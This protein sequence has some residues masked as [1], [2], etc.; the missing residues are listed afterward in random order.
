MSKIIDFEKFG[1]IVKFYLGDVDCEDYWGDDWD[2][3]PYEHNAGPV[4]NEYVIGTR[5]I[6]FDYDDFVLEPCESNYN[7]WSKED[8]KKGIIPCIVVVPNHL[9]NEYEEPIFDRFASSNNPEIKKFYFNDFL[10]PGV[11]Y[12]TK[13]L[14]EY[15]EPVKTYSK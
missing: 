13:E 10:I 14:N 11:S 7:Q 6:Y 8:M 5:T 15:F 3:I 12:D 1:T 4:Y 9:F 2:D